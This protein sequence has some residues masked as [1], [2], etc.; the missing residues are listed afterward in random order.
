VRELKDKMNEMSGISLA[1]ESSSSKMSKV[2]RSVSSS[3]GFRLQPP[4]P[5]RRHETSPAIVEL[6]AGA[7]PPG[8]PCSQ[9]PTDS[10]EENGDRHGPYPIVTSPVADLA[11][12]VA[13]S[14]DQEEE[15]GLT[16]PNLVTSTGLPLSLSFPSS[17]SRHGGQHGYGS[18]SLSS[19]T[20]SA[21]A[22]AAASAAASKA[23]GGGIGAGAAASSTSPHVISREE[24]KSS[25]SSSTKIVTDAGSSEKNTTTDSQSR[26][27]RAG[28]LSYEEESAA[29]ASH[30]RL[31]TPSGVS[32]EQSSG[33]R[34]AS[35]R[36]TAGTVG[37]GGL[38]HEEEESESMSE[39]R[40]MVASSAA[41]AGG[42][43]PSS[44]FGCYAVDSSSRK[45]ASSSW[46]MVDAGGRRITQ[47]TSRTSNYHSK[48]MSVSSAAGTLMT[49]QR[50]TAIMNSMNSHMPVEELERELLHLDDLEKLTPQ[51][52]MKAVESALVKYCSIL[53]SSVNAMKRD[54]D[55]DSLSEWM[56]KINAMMSKAWEVPSFGYDIGNTLCEILRKNGGLDMLIENC[57]AEHQDLQL[58]S[59][60]LLQNCLVTENRG[61]VVEKGLDK[62]VDVAKAFTAD[63]KDVERSRVGVG[64]LEHLFKHK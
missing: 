51:T 19:L 57:G 23:V 9:S 32:A 50:M 58:N 4:H 60:R 48:K 41:G 31:S 44:G 35:R 63:I 56:A 61:H 17:T 39:S 38:V 47:Q 27:L 15:G 18:G 29:S 21:I 55:E 5:M 7:A 49:A 62:V 64:I 37:G 54:C 33:L 30:A 14:S 46:T 6:P 25:S 52:S 59:A 26:R 8:G 28:D 10:L 13:T 45:E 3:G 43:D 22:A 12:L 2:N 11:E 24:R 20:P 34:K 1:A 53:S 42:N 40:A 36:L 16:S